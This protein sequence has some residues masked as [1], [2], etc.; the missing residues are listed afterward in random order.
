M[1]PEKRFPVDIVVVLGNILEKDNKYYLLN[2]N[3]FNNN[4]YP[5][6]NIG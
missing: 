1:K 6:M 3:E 5:I 4:E 2:C